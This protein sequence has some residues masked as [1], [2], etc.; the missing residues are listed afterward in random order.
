MIASRDKKIEKLNGQIYRANKKIKELEKENKELKQENEKLK[1]QTSKDYTN[2]SLPSSASNFPRKVKNSRAKS[3]KKPGGQLGHI[4][5]TRKRLIPNQTILLKPEQAILNNG[6][7]IKTNKT[8]TKQFI[9]ISFEVKVTD[10]I[11]EV[12]K[13]ITNNEEYYAPFPLNMNN[14]VNYDGGIKT[15]AYLLNN[16][17]N[18]SIDKIIEFFKQLSDDK[19]TLSKG[20]INNL[21]KQFSLKS[22]K[23][24][25]ELFNTLSKANIIYTDNTNARVNGKSGFVFVSTDKDKVIYNY[26][27]HKRHKGI[28]LTPISSSLAILVHDHDKSFYS[29]G[30]NHQECLAHILRYLQSSIDYETDIS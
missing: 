14:E 15:I 16:Y 1:I 25:N 10:Y 12:Y 17:C 30:T 9:D 19:L 6:D 13:N 20:F 28:K 11:A 23:E 2:S 8:I 5:H 29:Y 18:V 27:N 22:K 7:Y 24:I 26:S 4:G 21:N 3:N